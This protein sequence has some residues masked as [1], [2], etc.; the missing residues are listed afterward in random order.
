MKRLSL[1]LIMGIALCVGGQS[2]FAANNDSKKSKKEQKKEEVKEILDSGNYT[3]DV[4]R[5]LPMNGRSVNLTS[6]YSLELRSDSAISY[7]PY[8]GRAYSVPYGGGDG[9]RFEKAITDYSLSYDKKG[10][11]KIQFK[12]RTEEDNFSFNVQ[13]FS[14]GST[15]I[16][17]TP[18]NRQA[19]SY[20]GELNTVKKKE[21]AE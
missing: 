12:A 9:L 16:S 1:V 20:H 6:S 17:V 5:A 4:N 2:L 3:I 10:T 19:I 15:S 14:N 7:L 18:V 8:F 13:V 21:K 11:A